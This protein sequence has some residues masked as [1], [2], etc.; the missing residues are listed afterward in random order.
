MS[1]H[2]EHKT[3][4]HE[5]G[6]NRKNF[7][8][9]TYEKHYKPLLIISFVLLAFSFIVIGHQYVTTGDFVSR[10]VSLTGGLS[11]T[12]DAPDSSTGIILTPDDLQ[13][14]LLD[15]F[16]KSDVNVRTFGSASSLKFYLEI[17]NI[18]ETELVNALKPKFPN[19]NDDDFAKNKQTIGPTFGK[20]FFTQTLKAIFIAF[21]FMSIVIFIYFGESTREKWVAS[22]MTVVAAFMMFYANSAIM[23]IIP[24]L[25]FSILMIIYV[26]DSI[27][28]FGIVLCAFSDI[29]FSL[30][31]FNL[32]GHKLSIAS[33]AAFLMLVGYSIDTDILLSVRVLKRRGGTVFDRVVG[34]LETGMTMSLCA[35]VAVLA[36]HTFTHSIVVKEIMFVLIVGL[37]GDII[38]TW[39]QNAG[40]LRWHLESKGW[41]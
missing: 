40:I 28:A 4:G 3:D 15:K 17:S 21:L 11:L 27:P 19:L 20:S 25:L 22:I 36:A 9:T 41:K 12:L 16:P 23:Y 30:A 33:V 29:F 1:E 39:V 31:I 2:H 8:Y 6:D 5:H 14:Y 37:I 13:S 35:L 26:R 7:F 32:F 24:L 34:A 10:G 18:D 38:F